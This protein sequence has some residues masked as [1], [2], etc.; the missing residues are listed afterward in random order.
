MAVQKRNSRHFRLISHLSRHPARRGRHMPHRLDRRRRRPHAQ[1]FL[2]QARRQI[3]NPTAPIGK[4]GDSCLWPDPE[5]LDCA[6][7]YFYTVLAR[8]SVNNT[9]ESAAATC[10]PRDLKAPCQVDEI[11]IS[12]APTSGALGATLDCRPV[13]TP[14]PPDTTPTRVSSTG[15]K[16]TAQPSRSTKN[17]TAGLSPIR[18]SK[19]RIR[20]ISRPRT[21]TGSL[22]NPATT[23]RTAPRAMRATAQGSR[24]CPM[25]S[26]I[27]SCR[28]K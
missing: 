23:A 11:V 5:N 19:M 24:L 21:G 20:T 17:S 7:D 18:T 4:S 12:A 16:P 6:S 14:T 27:I 22:W 28:R 13:P 10:R 15:Q 26:R 25:I 1:G 2:Q 9:S 3:L 8:D